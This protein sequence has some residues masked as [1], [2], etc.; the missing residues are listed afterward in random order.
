[1]KPEDLHANTLIAILNDP[2]RRRGLREALRGEQGGHLPLRWAFSNAA[3][4]ADAA[5]QDLESAARALM[6]DGA[7]DL[8]D[9]LV[10]HPA[11]PLSVLVELCDAGRCVCALGHLPGPRDF[12][13]RMVERHG[14]EESILT[15]AL[16]LYQDPAVP[17]GEFALFARRHASLEWMLRALAP[18]RASN[19][20]KEEAYRGLLP[21]NED[22]IGHHAIGL[23]RSDERTVDDL[24]ALLDRLGSPTVLVMLLE[25]RIPDAAKRELVEQRAAVV[26]EV[27]VALERHRKLL[28][29]QSKDLG[30]P[31]SLELFATRDNE[32][33]F[34][35]AGNPRTA[36]E[37]LDELAERRGA[38]LAGKTRRR[39]R[40]TLI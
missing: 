30:A 2:E 37:V 21:G 12:L 22:A 29:A 1:V 13:L 17:T 33:L 3:A 32:I 24:A 11:M 34:E 6:A 35:L 26:P 9:D 14:F 10:V 20:E 4:E 28:R 31:E 16:D 36:R 18:A 39:A 27:A 19:P 5:P 23:A 38:E 40:V 7:D 15:V 8:L 25:A